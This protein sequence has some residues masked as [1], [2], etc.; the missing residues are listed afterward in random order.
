MRLDSRLTCAESLAVVL[1]ATRPAPGNASVSA[2]PVSFCRALL[3]V[4]VL[5]GDVAPP[6]PGAPP[7]GNSVFLERCVARMRRLLAN[8]STVV[9]YGLARNAGAVVWQV[10][11]GA[12]SSGD[13]AGDANGASHCSDTVGVPLQESTCLI[14]LREGYLHGAEPSKSCS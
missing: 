7:H 11:I 9:S 4:N 5:R 14:L 1:I 10:V 6:P 3:N 2:S 8:G 12:R 13:D